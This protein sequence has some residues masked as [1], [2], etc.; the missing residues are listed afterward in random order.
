MQ[1]TEAR[2]LAFLFLQ[3]L[4]D[5]VSLIDDNLLNCQVFIQCLLL[6]TEELSVKT[7]DQA[8]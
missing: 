4:Q 8:A 2:H 6:S 3:H 7:K 1:G 5:S